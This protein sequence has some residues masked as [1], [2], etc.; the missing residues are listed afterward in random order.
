MSIPLLDGLWAVV[1]NPQVGLPILLLGGTLVAWTYWNPRAPGLPGPFRLTWRWPDAERVSRTYYALARRRYVEVIA[2]VRERVNESLERRFGVPLSSVAWPALRARRA[3]VPARRQ[4]SRLRREFTA[5]AD[6]AF[7][8]SLPFRIRLAFWRSAAADEAR[9]RQRV[10][11]LI[12]RG[13]A[14]TERIEGM[15]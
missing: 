3:G 10:A 5:V 2:L 9:F 13:R 14:M 7:D 8:R 6:E 12:E 11:R 15:E 1:A 4:L